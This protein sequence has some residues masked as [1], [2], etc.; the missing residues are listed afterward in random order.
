MIQTARTLDDH[1]SNGRPIADIIPARSTRPLFL[2]KAELAELLVH[3][4]DSGLTG[5]LERLAGELTSDLDRL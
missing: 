1:A 5:D 2:S 3:Q 4:A